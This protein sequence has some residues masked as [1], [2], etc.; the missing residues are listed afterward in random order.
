[1]GLVGFVAL[2]GIAISTGI[3]TGLL[4]FSDQT[5]NTAHNVADCHL[6]GLSS[7][8]TLANFAHTL[9]QRSSIS[10]LGCGYDAEKQLSSCDSTWP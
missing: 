1:M 9:N 4:D 2:C 5:E 8:Q 10:G 7:N 3:Q 6:T